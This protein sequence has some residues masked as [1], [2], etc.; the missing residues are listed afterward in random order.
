MPIHHVALNAADYDATKRFYTDGL[1]LSERIEWGTPGARAC[2][3]A[4]PGGRPRGGVR[5]PRP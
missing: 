4:V 1:G 2:M 5:T 3:L